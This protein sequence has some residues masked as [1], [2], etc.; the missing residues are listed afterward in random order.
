MQKFHP[1]RHFRGPLRERDSWTC[2]Y[3]RITFT[4][5]HTKGRC[6]RCHTQLV[7]PDRLIPDRPRDL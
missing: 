1:P 7:D 2:D 5:L 6:P 4:P 3:C